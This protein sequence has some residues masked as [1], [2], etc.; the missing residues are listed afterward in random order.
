[1]KLLHLL[2]PSLVSAIVVE[3]CEHHD[4]KGFCTNLD[5]GFVMNRCFSMPVLWSKRISSY[6]IDGGCC[7]FYEGLQCEKESAL[8]LAFNREDGRLNGRF[9]DAM[10]S[11]KCQ[12][13]CKGTNVG[14]E[15]AGW[16]A[17]VFRTA[18]GDGRYRCVGNEGLS[19]VDL[20]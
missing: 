7:G 5:D 20:F 17:D 11:I 19:V 15:L 10:S 3:I 9:N 8:F 14:R 2:I 1:M 6:K 18:L 16:V 12:K 4:H 13:A